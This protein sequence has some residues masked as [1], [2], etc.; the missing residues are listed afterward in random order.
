MRNG[1]Y[2]LIAG[3]LLVF[4]GAGCRDIPVQEKK[5]SSDGPLTEI[6]RKKSD[7]MVAFAEFMGKKTPVERMQRLL[8]AIDNDPQPPFLV[9]CFA[10]ELEA[11]KDKKIRKEYQEK[12]IQVA[13]KHPS[14]LV[15]A[16]TAV[17]LLDAEKQY[18]RMIDLSKMSVDDTDLDNLSEKQFSFLF[19]LVNMTGK[20]Y[21]ELGDY[22]AGDRFFRKLL[23]HDRFKDNLKLIGY[24]MM[25]Y[26]EAVKKGSDKKDFWWFSKSEKMLY[27]ETL[28]NLQDQVA[29]ICFSSKPAPSDLVVIL[30]IYRHNELT[31][32]GLELLYSMLLSQPDNR[33]LNIY[34]AVYYYNA[35]MYQN[36]LRL[37]REIII[38]EPTRSKF[39]LELARAADRA[40]DY[41]S[42]AAAY[43]NFIGMNKN[44]GEAAYKLAVLYLKT[45]KMKKA[46]RVASRIPQNPLALYIAAIACRQQKNYSQALKY[47]MA[48]MKLAEKMKLSVLLNEDFYKTLAFICERDGKVKLASKYI[49]DVLKK[50]P[51]D[52]VLMNFLGYMWADHNM[53]LDQAY[54][55]I[56]AALKKSPD[57][58]AYLD[59]MAWVLFRQKK[60]QEAAKY[61]N[62]ALKICPKVP[63]AIIASHA[64]DIFHASGETEKA[65]KYWKMALEVFSPDDEVN[66]KD[67]TEKLTNI[68]VS[69]KE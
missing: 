69:S 61:I 48:S 1:I 63:D 38:K 43:K 3:L 27:A 39:F 46:E 21:I 28:K 44:R 32:E 31:E 12:F 42:A 22:K 53:N 37:W 64:G 4:A 60:Y 25:F 23:D 51:N 20:A 45:G 7:A 41:I 58:V 9:G 33:R 35:K 30:D 18:R 10:K 26:F 55:Y 50:K 29:E 16:M 5:K 67:I 13:E 47:I 15:L 56:A 65:V 19:N 34:L 52:P 54:K 14:S 62:K 40:G 49:Q 17:Y 36:A 68:K 59:S 57:N 8:V 6:S 2:W 11:E 66:R 24:S